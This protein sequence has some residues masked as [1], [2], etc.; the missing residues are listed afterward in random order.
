MRDKVIKFI[1][2]LFF[3]ALII[4]S[5]VAQD[6]SLQTGAT[7]SSTLDAENLSQV[8]P[9]TSLGDEE[10]ELLVSNDAKCTIISEFNRHLG[11]SACTSKWGTW[12]H[13]S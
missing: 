6:R 3:A 10:V 13:P 2:L 7:L 9:I 1:V 4:P 11:Q 8:F 12:Y 5:V